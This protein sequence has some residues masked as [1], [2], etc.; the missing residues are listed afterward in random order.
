[1]GKSSCSSV[2][3]RAAKR[4]K[5][6]L[7]TSVERASGR[8]TLLIA[9][10][11]RRPILRAF[12]TTNFVCGMGPS[13]AS[14][15]TITPSTMLRI[16]ST[17]PPK[18]AWPG[19]STM[20]MR[21]PFQTTEVALARIVMPRSFSRSFESITRSATRWFSRKAPDC[22]RSLSTRV[23]FPWSTWAMI[24]ML[25]NFMGRPKQSCPARGAVSASR[26]IQAGEMMSQGP[27]RDGPAAAIGRGAP[28]PP[29]RPCSGRRWPRPASRSGWWAASGRRGPRAK[30][31]VRPGAAHHH[32]LADILGREEPDELVRPVDDEKRGRL[33][34]VEGRQRGLQRLP[35]ADRREIARHHLE[36][37]ARGP[38]P[39]QREDQPVA[40]EEPARPAR[41]VDDRKLLLRGAQ[42]HLDRVVEGRA[43]RERL[44]RRHHDGADRQALGPVAE[45][46][47][48]RLRA[49]REID[50][51][52]DHDQH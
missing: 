13:A 14:T 40:G 11:G 27:Y 28:G 10:I 12:E 48:L 49:R 41:A 5:T 18:S 30:A 19:V 2:A 42:H 8:S 15:S 38:A 21:V 29:L 23:V 33:R 1:M 43:G 20:L 26:A 16:R 24:A 52:A 4:S 31:P 47:V 17:S 22:A 39:T 46:H 32:H 34:A 25:R 9:T 7:M 6:S 44:E 35:V 36:H 51:E 3:S 45:G 50:E 37:R